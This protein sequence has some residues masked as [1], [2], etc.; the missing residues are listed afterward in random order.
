ME[1]NFSPERKQELDFIESVTKIIDNAKRLTGSNEDH[2]EFTVLD[3][4]EKEHLVIRVQEIDK[5]KGRLYQKLDLKPS[6]VKDIEIWYGHLQ[7]EDGELVNLTLNFRQQ[8]RKNQQT[9][10]LIKAS[11]RPWMA[12]ED[13]PR[14]KPQKGIYPIYDRDTIDFSKMPGPIPLNY[15]KATELLEKIQKKVLSISN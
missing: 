14:R 10:K 12:D 3:I 11:T 15:E 5:K 8:E 6:K 13:V 9:M 2:Q 4:N 7:L 1:K